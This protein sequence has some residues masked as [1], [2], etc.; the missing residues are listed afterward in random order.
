[1]EIESA[2]RR[3]GLLITTE[4]LGETVVQIEAANAAAVAYSHLERA[5]SGKLLHAMYSADW[6]HFLRIAKASGWR[7]RFAEALQ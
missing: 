1:M 5:F 3:S 2:L 6:P 4:P 7:V